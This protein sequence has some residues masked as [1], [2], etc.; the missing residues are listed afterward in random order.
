MAS[1]LS[2]AA[3]KG[4]GAPSQSAAFGRF[5]GAGGIIT[6]VSSLGYAVFFLLV[7]G[8]LHTYLPPIF[9]G[10][11]GF[12][13]TTI[14]VAVYDRV[15]VADA[16]FAL[17]GLLIGVVGQ[18]GAAVAA[19]YGLATAISALKASGT[20]ATFPN[21]ADPRG[22]L[23]FGISGVSFLVFAWLIVRSGRL[24]RGLGYLGYANGILV[25][26]LYLGA[27]LTSNDTKSLFILV[28]GGL[29]SL[30]T[31]PIWYLWAGIVLLRGRAN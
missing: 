4:G 19:A 21:Q 9:L 8:S 12:F 14:V 17:W 22:F 13:A 2:E 11:G 29:A 1:S 28:P 30:I 7:Q 3:G 6:G 26:A 27:L 24:P 25:I 31:T 5:A 10:L 18:L 20:A 15:R 16:Q 23:T